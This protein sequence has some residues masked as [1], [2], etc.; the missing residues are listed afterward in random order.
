MEAMKMENTNNTLRQKRLL[1]QPTSADGTKAR[2]TD[3]DRQLV[4]LLAIVL[5][6]AKMSSVRETLYFLAS[7]RV[8]TRG[9]LQYSL[10]LTCAQRAVSFATSVSD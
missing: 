10:G 6:L 3:R 7:H 8:R 9:P 1:K 4:G 2:P 5:C